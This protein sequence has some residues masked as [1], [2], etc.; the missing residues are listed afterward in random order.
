MTVGEFKRWLLS[1]PPEWNGKDLVYVGI[2]DSDQRVS[3][4]VIAEVEHGIVMIVS[5]EGTQWTAFGTK[6]D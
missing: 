2:D 3:Q 5:K 1:L 6:Q 4:L